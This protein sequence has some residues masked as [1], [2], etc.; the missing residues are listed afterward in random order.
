MMHLWLQDSKGKENIM[1]YIADTW[2]LKPKQKVYIRYNSMNYT[3]W[4]IMTTGGCPDCLYLHKN[5][6]WENLMSNDEGCLQYHST[7]QD[8]INLVESLGYEIESE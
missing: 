5:G 7:K 3:G 1:A 2:F 6:E 8:A 4:Y